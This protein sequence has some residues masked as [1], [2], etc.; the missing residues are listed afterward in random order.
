[1]DLRRVTLRDKPA[2]A[3]LF[4]LAAFLAALVS[5]FALLDEVPYGIPFLTFFPAVILTAFLSGLWPS[6]AVGIASTLAAWFFF[7]PPSWSFALFPSTALILALFAGIVAV[8]IAVIDVMHQAL[9][10]L[11]AEKARSAALAEQREVLFRELQHRISNNLAIV[12]ALL[13]L[14]RADVEDEKAK[15]A[16]TE[17][18]TRLALIGKIHRK[19]H[20]PAGAQFRFGAFMEDLCHDVLEAS[21]AQNVVCMVSAA[22]AEIPPDKVIPIALIATELISNALEHGFANRERGTI[23]IDFTPLGAD[24]VLTVADD[25]NGLPD[26]FSPEATKSLGLKIVR[27]LARQIDATFAMESVDGTRC[28]LVFPAGSGGADGAQTAPA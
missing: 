21:G 22:E 17:A 27:S 24:H 14:E 8:N 3:W 7:L 19:L 9:D 28:R 23:R 6:V 11:G 18:A 13:N 16:L 2:G 5:R 15:Q 1:M 4:A 10:R 26:G 25:G 20:D 12:S